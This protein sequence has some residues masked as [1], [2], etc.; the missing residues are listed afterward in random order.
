MS[1]LEAVVASVCSLDGVSDAEVKSRNP[2][3]EI[4]VTIGAYVDVRQ[5]EEFLEEE[6]GVSVTGMQSRPSGR[7]VLEVTAKR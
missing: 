3:Q 5:I 2:S 6:F 1:D 4:E 7:T